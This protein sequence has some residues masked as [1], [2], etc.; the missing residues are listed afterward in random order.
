MPYSDLKRAQTAQNKWRK[1][2]M[3]QFVIRL[4]KGRDDDIIEFLEDKKYNSEENVNACLKRLVR[5]EIKRIEY[6]TL[7]LASVASEDERSN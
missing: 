3:Q 1:E 6:H 2:N 7:D 5:D 4:V